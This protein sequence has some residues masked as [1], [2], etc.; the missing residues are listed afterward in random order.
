MSKKPISKCPGCK[1]LV[2]KLEQD[3][4][5]LIEADDL[6]RLVNQLKDKDEE[7]K[8]KLQAL[9]RD[10]TTMDA[11]MTKENVFLSMEVAESEKELENMLKE[12]DV[13]VENMEGR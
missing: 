6:P 11:S 3:Y 7:L 9:R 13:L 1:L 8:R 2:T 12:F 5:R 10:Y 4:G